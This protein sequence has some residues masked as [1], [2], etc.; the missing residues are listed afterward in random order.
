MT[1]RTVN[2][3][4]VMKDLEEGL[5]DIPIMEKHGISP[6]ELMLIIKKFNQAHVRN[7]RVARPSDEKPG[8]RRLWPRHYP[9]ISI[10]VHIA[11]EPDSRGWVRD[12]NEHGLQVSGVTTKCGD[13][14]TFLI[15]PEVMQSKDALV[16]DAECRWSGEDESSG[17]PVSGFE[18]TGISRGELTRLKKLIELLTL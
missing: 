10:P 1:K 6:H 15:R 5:G 11:N 12:M 16:F 2:V 7:S 9:F 18:I 13:T 14:K 4:A 3:R 8:Q 17:S